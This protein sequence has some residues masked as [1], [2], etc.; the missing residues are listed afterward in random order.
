MLANPI[1]SHA[2]PTSTCH[3]EPACCYQSA[4]E[5]TIACQARELDPL[6]ARAGAAFRR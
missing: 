6:A 4:F 5:A 2:N 3:R 1:G